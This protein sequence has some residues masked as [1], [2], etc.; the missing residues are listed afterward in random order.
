MNSVKPSTNVQQSNPLPIKNSSSSINPVATFITALPGIAALILVLMRTSST[1]ATLSNGGF[2]A[3]LNGSLYSSA[4]VGIGTNNPAGKLQVVGN[5][6]ITTGNLGVGTISTPS[7]L[8]VLET[9]AVNAYVTTIRGTNNLNNGLLIDL[10]NDTGNVDLLRMRSNTSS[11][12]A[13]YSDGAVEIGNTLEDGALTVYG[14]LVVDSNNPS[15][16]VAQFI[17]SNS[18]ANSS[19]LIDARGSSNNGM[20]LTIS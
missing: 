15:I 17:Q 3:G 19:L 2:T 10:L 4:N 13:V 8:T 7:K 12:F 5:A 9:G 1:A 16:A 18:S 6:Y 20:F 14:S 11:K